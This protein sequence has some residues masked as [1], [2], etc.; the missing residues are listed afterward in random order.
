MFDET[1]FTLDLYVEAVAN[2]FCGD[3]PE[4]A[5]R[6]AFK[7]LSTQAP[8]MEFAAE[9]GRMRKIL[10][11]YMDP[12]GQH[13]PMEVE[14][15]LVMGMI[16][17]Y[18]SECRHVLVHRLGCLGVDMPSSSG[19][20]ADDMQAVADVMSRSADVAKRASDMLRTGGGFGPEDAA[21]LPHLVREARNAAA[22]L[23]GMA[24]HAERRVLGG[25]RV[26]A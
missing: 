4:H 21:D 25:L 1:P 23:L 14:E 6:V 18:R 16:E 26:V 7:P 13:V 8:H 19:C 20:F 10:Q 3:V 15:A 24:D 12:D 22:R 2:W 5:R 11:R 9:L 17:P